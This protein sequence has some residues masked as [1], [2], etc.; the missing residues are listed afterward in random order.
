MKLAINQIVTQKAP[1]RLAGI[2]SGS[3][4]TGKIIKI[5]RKNIIIEVPYGGWGGQ[6]PI[7]QQLTISIDSLQ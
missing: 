3:G 7:M 4:I 6:Q 5:A 2:A 1:A